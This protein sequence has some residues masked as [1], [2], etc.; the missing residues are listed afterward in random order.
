MKKKLAN[1]VLWLNANDRIYWGFGL[2]VMFEF[3][4]FMMSPLNGVSFNSEAF[5]V[6]NLTMLIC[7][8]AACA[9][10]LVILGIVKIISWLWWLIV[11]WAE[12][13]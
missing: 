4:A 8:G 10:A 12:M 11:D 9:I 3:L 2:F 5:V 7:L 13:V 6:G 1:A